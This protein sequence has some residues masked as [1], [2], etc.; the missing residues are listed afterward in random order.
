MFNKIYLPLY[1]AFL[2][3]SRSPSP[4]RTFSLEGRF[5]I[6]GPSNHS[7][8]AVLADGTERGSKASLASVVSGGSPR[9]FSS[10]KKRNSTFSGVV[11]LAGDGNVPDSPIGSI[12]SDSS[13]SP[14]RRVPVILAA[15][16]IH[17]VLGRFHLRLKYDGSK[18][19]LLVHLVEGKRLF[20]VSLVWHYV[21]LPVLA[22]RKRVLTKYLYTSPYST[23]SNSG[24]RYRIPRSLRKDVP[25]AGWGAAN[26]TDGCA[27]YRN[28]SVL[29]PAA[30]LPA[31]TS[32]SRQE[33]LCAAGS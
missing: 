20:Q 5:P 3:K 23:R 33:Q 16:D 9:D 17:S 2:K 22:K 21:P 14:R 15:N 19:E 24:W 1:N 26:T 25:G 4:M 32:Q 11:S 10:P 28:A 13:R 8:A 18:E 27:S 29:W 30:F 6:G 7:A 12:R 31:E